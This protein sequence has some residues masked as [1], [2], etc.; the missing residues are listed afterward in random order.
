MPRPEGHLGEQTQYI[1]NSACRMPRHAA[2]T[3]GA[4]MRADAKRRR[5]AENSPQHVADLTG[6]LRMHR[7][8]AEIEIEA[9]EGARTKRFPESGRS[10]SRTRMSG[11]SAPTSP[12]HYTYVT[13]YAIFAHH[14]SLP[15]KRS[16]LIA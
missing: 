5:D 15:R 1:A 7:P 11:S 2:Q 9:S 8:G 13:I 10:A 3:D 14:R 4:R 6:K 12:M 16:T